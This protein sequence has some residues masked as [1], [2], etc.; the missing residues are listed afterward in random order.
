MQW[1]WIPF[2][3][4]PFDCG[5]TPALQGHHRRKAGKDR[6]AIDHHRAGAALPEAPAGFRAVELELAAQKIA[7][8][9]DAIHFDE[10]ISDGYLQPERPEATLH[11]LDDATQR[12]RPAAV[13]A[14]L[15]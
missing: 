11:Q 1:T 8:S 4:E 9:P 13:N 2:G 5:D 3:A 6:L 7:A 14:R 10:A 12:W 15:T